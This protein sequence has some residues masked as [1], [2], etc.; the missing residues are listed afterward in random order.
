M[1]SSNLIGQDIG[2]KVDSIL[3]EVVPALM[4]PG[5]TIG[6]LKNGKQEII[7]SRGLAS[8]EYQIP[9]SDST[10][11][12][13][14]S[15]TKQ[16]TSAC[17]G[18]LE[19]KGLLEVDDDVRKYI[20]ELKFYG[21]TIRIKHLLS[22]TSGIRNHNVLLDLMGFDFQYSGYTNQM[23]QELMFR[24]NGI[25]N[26]PGDKMLYSNTNYVILALII[27]RV[28]GMKI[29]HFAEKELFYP[30][31]MHD[32]FYEND[33]SSI[34]RNRAAPYY[35]SGDEYKEPKSLSLCVGA[36]GVYSS[37]KD[38][39]KWM[40]LFRNDDHDLSYI[41]SYLTVLDTLNDGRE[42]TSA[43]GVFVSRYKN[44]TTI[45][46]SG[47]D[48]GLRSQI[49]WLPE[50]DLGVFVFANSDHVNAVE[51][52][53]QLVD[54]FLNASGDQ[55]EQMTDYKHSMKELAAFQG[56]YQELNSDMKMHVYL[57]NDSL[58]AK[59]SMGGIPVYLVSQSKGKFHRDDNASVTYNFDYRVQDDIDMSVDFGGAEFY[60][61]EIVLTERP[62]ENLQDYVGEYYSDELEVI[63]EL[64]ME[65]DKLV[66]HYPNNCCYTL[67]E[68][69]K[70]VFG[71]NRRTKYAF[72][73]DR[74]GNVISFTVAS[75]G[76]V[77]DILFKRLD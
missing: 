36:G 74:K 49:I 22:H 70:D 73:R 65:S 77:K 33:L 50:L 44:L 30:L 38:M 17:I 47:R 59:S 48:W 9:F 40:K 5:I 60:F 71:A 54:L 52:S 13:L 12:E 43:R 61:E 57:R 32:T 4:G 76:T 63:Y 46:H 7:R 69:Q 64:R 8:L 14:A 42:M 75:E 28:S 19:H 27:E 55:R 51:I 16:F 37:V 10:V 15:V 72:K 34:V 67:T 41:P 56:I 25:N 66:L 20:P 31:G 24:Q 11:F 23:I 18:V 35:R 29:H 53:Y 2:A 26:R 62:N 58:F 3:T 6:I 68:G 45:N 39:L 1:V 21:D